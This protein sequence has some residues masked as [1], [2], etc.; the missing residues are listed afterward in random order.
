MQATKKSSRFIYLKI[1][2]LFATTQDSFLNEA[3]K[4]QNKTAAAIKYLSVNCHQLF[5]P[6][7]EFLLS[8]ISLIRFDI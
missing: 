6:R 1:F 8:W 4:K 3:N 5:F 2:F 7:C